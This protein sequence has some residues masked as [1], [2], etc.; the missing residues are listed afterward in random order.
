MGTPPPLLSSL[1]QATQ[2]Q[3]VV[4]IPFLAG[5][6][7][8]FLVSETEAGWWIA[9]VVFILGGIGGGY[10]HESPASGAK[11]GAIAGACFGTGVVIAD[12]ITGA[13]PIVDTPDPMIVFIALTTVG[14][15]VL[16]SI[17]GALRERADGAG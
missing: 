11:R 15:S 3:L 16:A 2:V 6:F 13:A 1:P 5:G 7:L 12:A 14:G 4:F 10:E 9:N 17:G 8:G